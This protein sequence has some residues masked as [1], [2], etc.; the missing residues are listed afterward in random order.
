M[1]PNILYKAVFTD[2]YITWINFTCRGYNLIGKR[3]YFE[4]TNELA[5][6][7]KGTIKSLRQ[8]ETIND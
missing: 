2:G 7:Y 1:L 3:L 5:K 8:V 6:Y 4:S